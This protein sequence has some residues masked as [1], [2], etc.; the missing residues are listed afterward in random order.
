MLFVSIRFDLLMFFS[1]F[2]DLFA[3]IEKSTELKYDINGYI[4]CSATR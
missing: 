2:V 1:K 4:L 3:W